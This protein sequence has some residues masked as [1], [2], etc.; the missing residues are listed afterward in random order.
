MGEQKLGQCLPLYLLNRAVLSSIDEDDAL[1]DEREQRQL[2][3]QFYDRCTEQAVLILEEVAALYVKSA[4]CPI[5][6]KVEQKSNRKTLREHWFLEGRLFRK[7]DRFS[8]TSWDLYLGCLKDKGPVISLVFRPVNGESHGFDELA[9]LV[10]KERGLDA[11]PHTCFAD[12]ADYQHGVIA[13]SASVA[14]GTP[15]K[16]VTKSMKEGTEQ[17]FQTF[18][19]EFREAIGAQ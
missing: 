15:F 7:H 11:H 9:A 14:A 10:T 18:G 17:F 8:K 19:E 13:T 4:S 2:L 12:D 16:E 6:F 5:P 3:N 1:A